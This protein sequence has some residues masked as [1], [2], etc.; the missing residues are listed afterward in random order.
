[1]RNWLEWI[2]FSICAVIVLSVS[3]ALVYDASV[4]HQ[5]HAE[6]MVELG[7]PEVVQGGHMIPVTAR[8]LGDSSAEEVE[9][10]VTLTKDDGEE[11]SSLTFP[12]LPRRSVRKGWVVFESDP[13]PP[14]RV[15]ARTV[16]F[17]DP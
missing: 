16:G 12:F 13:T 9:V 7:T 1:M 15:K 17:K 5:K 11:I 14:A 2:V 8:N 4:N 10:E 3:G 6:I